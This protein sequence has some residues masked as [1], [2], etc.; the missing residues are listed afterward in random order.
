[1]PSICRDTVLRPRELD[2]PLSVPGFADFL[3]T[4]LDKLGIRSA[5]I[6]GTSLGAHGAATIACKAPDRVRGLILVGAVGLVPLGAQAGDAIRRNVQQTSREAIAGKL[7]F[8]LANPKAISPALIKEEWRIK[9]L[10]GGA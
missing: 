10:A 5:F 9:Q 7:A 8:V 1:M 3:T 6:V 2:I 4:A